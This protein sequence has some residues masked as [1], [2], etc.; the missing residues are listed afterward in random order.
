MRKINLTEDEKNRIEK[1]ARTHSNSRVRERAKAIEL[2]NKGKKVKE[3]VE[4]LNRCTKTLY[5]WFDRYEEFGID[6]LFDNEHTSHYIKIT[7]EIRKYMEELTES[8]YIYTANSL[9]QAIKDKFG[10]TV[11]E[12]TIRYNLKKKTLSTKGQERL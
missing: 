1:L 8:E 9:I 11:H 10:V 12:S 6:G 5:A 3:I 2:L 4:I 7:D